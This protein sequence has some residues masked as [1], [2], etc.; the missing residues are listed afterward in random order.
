MTVSGRVSYHLL[1]SRSNH[2]K[3][4]NTYGASFVERLSEK[5]TKPVGMED[6]FDEDRVEKYR[7]RGVRSRTERLVSRKHS[8]I[9]DDGGNSLETSQGVHTTVLT[10]GRLLKTLLRGRPAVLVLDAAERTL[11]LPP[12]KS[13]AKS[14]N[15]LGQLLQ[16][17]KCININLTIVLISSSILLEHAR[18]LNVP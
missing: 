12:R 7:S 4:L 5:Q 8:E 17:S 9:K 10:F 11:N 15:L 6:D 2:T 14:S 16:L 18:K 13:S 3:N 1:V